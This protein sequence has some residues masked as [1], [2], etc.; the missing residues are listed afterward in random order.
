VPLSQSINPNQQSGSSPG[1]GSDT[2]GKES[3]QISASISLPK[4][5]GAIRGMGEKFAANPVTGTG[6]MTV[7]IATSAGRS[8]SGFS[9]HFGLFQFWYGLFGF[10]GSLWRGSFL[11][12][13][14]L[15]TFRIEA[16]AYL[17]RGVR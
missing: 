11:M 13:R 2:N 3:F 6:S 14:K 17:N 4:G 8:D 7:P 9:F 12:E 16:G 10:D 1:S 15:D 5:G